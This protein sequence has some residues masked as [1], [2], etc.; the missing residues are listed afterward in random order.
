MTIKALR[1]ENEK[2]RGLLREVREQ[3][4]PHH[5][6]LLDRIDAALGKDEE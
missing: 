6:P 5:D 2:L 1:A 3:F 4:A